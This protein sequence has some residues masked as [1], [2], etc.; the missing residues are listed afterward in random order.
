MWKISINR[1]IT[2]QFS[3]PSK[4][5]FECFHKIATVAFQFQISPFF[6]LF[7]VSNKK[8]TKFGKTDQKLQA[9][10]LI[11]KLNISEKQIAVLKCRKRQDNILN[12]GRRILNFWFFQKVFQRFE[13]TP[14]TEY[15]QD[16]VK[17]YEADEANLN[18][19]FQSLMYSIELLS[20][21]LSAQSHS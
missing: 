2:C 6:F 9:C 15:T 7:H 18:D 4:E 21:R 5:D 11:Q 14:I 10:C 19:S 20:Y 1:R 13:W 16:I 17:A 8:K 12:E 3:V